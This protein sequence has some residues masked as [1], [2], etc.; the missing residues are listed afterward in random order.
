MTKN[1]AQVLLKALREL[2]D[3]VRIVN[4]ET[5][6]IWEVDTKGKMNHSGTCYEVWNRNTPC[7]NCHTLRTCRE[8][9]TSDKY[10]TLNND[11]YHITSKPI[12]IDDKLFA[13]EIV[14]KLDSV[15]DVNRREALLH[16]Q[17]RNM[18]IINI[19]ASEYSSVY[20][21]DLTTD[22][23]DPYTMN[24]ETESEFGH[25]F[26]SGIRYSDAFKLYVDTLVF[27][28]DKSSMLQAGS[29]K[30]IIKQLKNKKT[31][32]TTYRSENN[33]DPHYCEMKF[34]KVGNI[35]DEPT[36]VALGFSDKNEEILREKAL[37]RN[38]EIIQTLADEYTS[39]YYIDLVSGEITIPKLRDNLRKTL[40][41]E[42]V[43]ATNFSDALTIFINTLVKNSDSAE[44]EKFR[45]ADYIRSVLKNQDIYTYTCRL[46]TE[47]DFRYNEMKLVK[48]NADGE[49][50]AVV[51]GFA[52]KDEEI[53]A[54]FKAEIERRRN[55]EIIEILASEYT[56]VYYIDLTTDGLTPYT[57]NEELESEF[58]Q[59]FRS[60]IKYSDAFNMYVDT[61]VYDEDK[62][63]MLTAGSIKNILGE[64]KTKKTFITTYRSENGG[65]PHYCEMKFVKVGDVHGEP[66]EVA[67][68]FADKHEEIRSE[69]ER[70]AEDD[71]NSEIIEI[72]AS[73]YSSVYYIDLTTDEL[74]P[75]TMNEETENQ[76]GVLFKNM[77]YSDAYRM[78]VDKLIV[79]EDKPMM[80]KAGSVGNIMK[81]LRHKK[82]FITTY[83][84]D[85]NGDPHYC[86]MK[87]VKVGTEDGTPKAVALGFADKN[88]ELRTRIEQD[89]ARKRNTEIIEILASE[90]TSVYYID[91]TT[92]E[93]DPYTMNEETESEFGQ[94]FR[95][96]IKYSD[97]FKLYVDTLVYADDKPMMLKAGSIY[98]I[99]TELSD[100]K[101]FLTTYRSDNNGDPHYCEMKFV[102]VG[103]DENPQ[104]VALGFSDKND[105][106]RSAML[107]TQEREKNFEIID[108]L[109]SEYSSVYY[110]DLNTDELTTYTMNDQTKEFFEDAFGKGITYSEAFGMYVANAVAPESRADML[111]A[112]AIENIRRSLRSQKTFITTYL[113]NN[114]EYSEMKFVKVGDEMAK[115]QA[116]ALGFSVV[117]EAYRKELLNKQRDEFINGL[118]D[119]Y[120]AVFHVDG[121]NEV[122]EAV[123][124]TDSY[125]RRN[126]SLENEMNYF[127]YVESVAANIV[128]EDKQA[129]I[130]ALSP[131]NIHSEFAKGDAFFHNYR[132][133][134][135]NDITY[136]QLKVIHTGDWTVDHN[137]L[138]G[139]HNM[140]ELTK[141]QVAQEEILEG[142]RIEAESANR[143]KSTFL[144][145]MSHDIRT[146]MN[147]IIG[148][149]NMALKHL[150]NKEKL[151]DCLEKVNVSSHHL[152]SIINDVLDMARIES[153]KVTIEED[154]VYITDAAASLAEIVRQSVKDKEITFITDYSAVKHNCVFADE[155]RVNRVLM[156][157]ANNA[158]KYT[159]A[160]GTVKCIIAETESDRPGYASYDFI[161]ED[162]GIGMSEEFLE[163][164]FEAFTRES[165]STITGIQ[166]TGLGMAITKELV[167]LMKGTINIES[168]LGKGTKVTIHFEFRIADNENV[169]TE[170][171]AALDTSILKGKRILLVEDNEL[172]REIAR[173]IL[174]ELEITVEEAEDGTIAVEKCVNAITAGDASKLYDL[175][176]MDIQMPIMDG[177]KATQQIRDY[178]SDYAKS[179]PIIAM[180]ANAFA[181]D[182]KKAF[183][184]G[185]NAHLAKPININDLTRTLISFAKKK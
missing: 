34:V 162:T 143:A 140:D 150:D 112:G 11:V 146:P 110:I 37:E 102:K 22:E 94:I 28:E 48:V 164:I 7:E 81:E 72:L 15:K 1:E 121:Y 171:E 82:T 153:G 31:F 157:I 71:R 128:P 27:G 148:F 21:I 36:A 24:A 73:E 173:E 168:K 50:N 133:I 12:E 178:K 125:K 183:E 13:L 29:I 99:L 40:G 44:M 174:E 79:A 80:L 127:T 124:M 111:K 151:L 141:A 49:A 161:V 45:S 179:V 67:L 18:E 126:P 185:M 64:L 9:I 123:R 8:R 75:Y 17:E 88:D 74:T 182:K 20:Y 42:F 25:I 41:K 32:I 23:L 144:F 85:N 137:F 149:N 76:F 115:P 152:L 103:D 163:H 132:I 116:V 19:L 120:E 134:K 106:I 66:K 113:N 118:A 184:A 2:F 30:N 55:N 59:I 122:I 138:I 170:S 169:S 130:D 108:I 54:Q 172:N 57:M 136:Y 114:N 91:L 39:V 97:A 145:N 107:E 83:R 69:M 93:L 181:E 139:V 60:G 4:P 180:T 43:Q 3:V 154:K 53:R 90:Y 175:I 62:P 156:N 135:N 117:D 35:S 86:E 47:T 68:G 119:D 89:T 6:D 14:S 100:K 63:A 109:A 129:F 46:G 33:G 84:S 177:Y 56:S 131:E 77:T 58:G 16:E 176:L 52:D 101:T 98:N 78:Y 147:A 92:D 10:E 158:I 38:Q 87:F 5:H 165:T 160:G 70:K 155:L 159:N 166:G 26:R 65:D 104:A 96:G 142:A 105:E 61:L 51:L 167:E 95:S